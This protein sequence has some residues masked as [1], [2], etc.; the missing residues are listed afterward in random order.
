ME[1]ETRHLEKELSTFYEE[2]K[3]YAKI[4]VKMKIGPLKC[5]Q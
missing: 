5:L 1:R 4:K 3:F 2:T